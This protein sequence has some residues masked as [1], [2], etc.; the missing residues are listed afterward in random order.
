L[1]FALVDHLQE[2]LT[3]TRAV[4]DTAPSS[5][6]VFETSDLN[7]CQDVAVEIHPAAWEAIAFTVSTVVVKEKVLVSPR[8]ERE[9]YCFFF[10]QSAYI[11][12]KLS[13]RRR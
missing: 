9:R 3:T 13:S 8:G 10:L 2:L 1:V 4:F 6:L 5:S 12:V 11:Y 7:I